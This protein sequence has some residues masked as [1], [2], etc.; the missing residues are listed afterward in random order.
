MKKPIFDYQ[1]G[2]LDCLTS[3]TTEAHFEF[4]PGH[5][6]GQKMFSYFARMFNFN[7]NEVRV[8]KNKIRSAMHIGLHLLGWPW[9]VEAKNGVLTFW[10]GQRVCMWGSCGWGDRCIHYSTLSLQGSGWSRELRCWCGNGSVFAVGGSIFGH[11]CYVRA[12]FYLAK[13]FQRIA[14]VSNYPSGN[15]SSSVTLS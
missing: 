7:E 10:F 11:G 14:S 12:G 3:P 9:Q 1:W 8:E 2:R 6:T 15:L 5:L 4:P 13:M